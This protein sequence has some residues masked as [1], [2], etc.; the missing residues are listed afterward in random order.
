MNRRSLV[1]SAQAWTAAD[2]SAGRLIVLSGKHDA[3][4]IP[5]VLDLHAQ[6]GSPADSRRG[7][8]VRDQFDG[9][10]RADRSGSG[11][12]VERALHRGRDASDRWLP[13][14]STDCIASIVAAR[15]ALNEE[16]SE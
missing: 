12:A 5:V 6:P 1:C 13:S 15:S 10:E 4:C 9:C 11:G 7:C 16:A 3:H 8:E 2:A 14:A